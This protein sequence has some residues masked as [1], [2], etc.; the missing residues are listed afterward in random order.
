LRCPSCQHENRPQAKFCEECAAALAGTCANCGARLSATAKFCP[1]CA[2][3]AAEPASPKP[4]FAS[5]EA[6]TPKHLAEK[7]LTSRSALEGERKQVTVLFCDVVESTGLA[8]RLDPEAMHE[9]M[10]KTLR[11]MAEA[12]HRYQ[13]TVNQFLGDGLMALFGAPVAL[14]DHGLRA[15]QAALAIRETVNGYS[16]QLKRER[17]I[18]IHLRIGL[19]SGLVVVGRIGDDLRMD[20]TAIG[21]TT[22]LAA[23][24]QVLAEPGTIL[25]TEAT[26]RL[27]EGYIRS[28]PL[29]AVQVK[30]RSDPVIAYRVTGRRARRTRLELSAERGLTPLVGR[31]QELELLHDRLVRAKAGHGQ[32]VGIMGEPGA[33]KSRLLYEFRKMLEGE[34][35]TWL[36][37]HCVAYGQTTPYLPILEILRA[38]FQIEEEDN[39][40]QI[41]EKLREGVRQL[42]PALEPTLPFL[43]ELLGLPIEDERLR[44]MDAKDKRQKTFEAVRALTVAGSQRRPLIVIV[45]DLHWID[46]TSEDYLAFLIESLPGMSLLLLISHRPGYVVRSAN[47][48]YYTQV[49]LDLLTEAEAES[50]V[51]TLLGSRRQPADLLPIIWEKA[52]GNPLFVEEMTRS[53]WERGLIVRTDDEIRWARDA[54]VELPMSVHDIIR[55]RIDGLEE[56][57]KRMVQTAAVIGREFGHRLL[58]RISEMATEVQRYVETLKHLELIHEKRFFPEL[59]YIF[60][61]AVTQDVAYQSLLSQRRREI[62]RIIGEAIEDLYGERLDEHV[63]ILAYHYARSDRP[64]K[65]VEFA[66]Q[67][68]DKAARL[69][70]NAEATT[71]YEEALRMLVDAP[72]SA[73]RDELHVDATVK[74]ASVAT[75]RQHFERDLA[76]LEVAHAIAGRLADQH[77]AAQVLYWTART[78]YVRGSL[79]EAIQ[80]AERSLALGDALGGDDDLVVWPINLTGRIYTVIGEYVKATSMLQ[81]C[82]ALFERLGN[83]NELATASGIL[84]V[85]L[86]ATGEFPEA[87]KFSDQGLQIALEI[88]NLPAQAAAYYYRAIVYERN[89]EWGRVVEDC[90]AGLEVAQRIPDPFRIYVLTCLHGYGM[91]RLGQEQEGL[92]SLQRGIR[93]AEELGTTYLLAWAVTWLCDCHLARRDWDAAL[94]RA[95]R[96]LSLVATGPDVYGESLAARCFGEALCQSDS[97]RLQEAEAHIRRA[98]ALQADKAMKPQLARSYVACARLLMVK[99]ERVEAREYLDKARTIFRGLGMKW[100]QERLA[101]A[102]TDV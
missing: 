80:Y 96:A 101:E 39:L 47:K 79:N 8:E 88:Q 100:D 36:A 76:N 9:L 64:D 91:F 86:S 18:E 10:D 59:E 77:R 58:V 30:G 66:L 14:E 1:E 27:A 16:E 55:A 93:L 31:E 90:R 43:G 89:G 102:F 23:R 13:G 82:V 60:K 5:P 11:L 71:F 83:L 84:G 4:R 24:M 48:T 38:N 37:G 63:A 99:G 26:Y 56:P 3:P 61:H 95:S 57:V 81:R 40:L 29:G 62:H 15:V 2:R 51:A 54:V 70:A 7:I 72:P 87:L 92:E 34:R 17:G 74:L 98:I 85:V 49:A 53:L 65:A 45:E 73:R 69:S 68:G 75:T 28:E 32:V 67:A 97:A 22:N 50:M 20:Y 46:K 44:Q 19:N 21:D 6:Y 25:I 35:L 33:G 78:H 12:V 52:E 94:A 41:R 42:D